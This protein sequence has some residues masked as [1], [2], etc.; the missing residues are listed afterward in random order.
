MEI[1][2]K[3]E[4]KFWKVNL[5]VLRTQQM[6]IYFKLKLLKTLKRLGRQFF[7]REEASQLRWIK[8]T[9]FEFKVCFVNELEFYL[10][11][12]MYIMASLFTSGYFYSEGRL[13]VFQ[14]AWKVFREF[15]PLCYKQVIALTSRRIKDKFHL[16]FHNFYK[17]PSLLRDS[18][19]FVKPLK[20]RVKTYP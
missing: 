10:S 17:L 16:Y 15:C 11:L 7:Q 5:C 12:D 3:L 13:I 8:F 6:F 19:N 18:G 2:S 4:E 9:Q 1:G 14:R 20:I